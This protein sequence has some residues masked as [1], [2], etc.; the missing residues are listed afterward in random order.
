[1]NSDIDTERLLFDALD[2]IYALRRALA[3]EAGVVEAHMTYK[4]FPKSRRR[5][6]EHQAERMRASARGDVQVQ[7]SGCNAQSLHNAM[8]KAGASNTF[9][10]ASWKAECDRSLR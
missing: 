9:T 5:I 1:V 8:T 4:S 2:E 7:Y 6:A 10:T 3:F